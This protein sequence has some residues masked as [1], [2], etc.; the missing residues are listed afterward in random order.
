MLDSKSPDSSTALR[1]RFLLVA[2]VCNAFVITVATAVLIGWLLHIEHLKRIAPGM[3]AMN[4]LTAV[5]FI[6]AAA[7]LWILHRQPPTRIARVTAISVCGVVMLLSLFRLTAIFGWIDLG[8]DQWLFRSSLN[9]NHQAPNTAACTGI[10]ALSIALLDLQWSRRFYPTQLLAAGGGA[11]AAVALVG[12]AYSMQP[13]YGVST[14][15]PMA[16]HSAVC[17]IVLCF[18]VLCTRPDQGV[19]AVVTGDDL[20]G[21]LA[22]RLL[23]ITI[24]APILIGWLRLIAVRRG[25]VSD[26]LGNALLVMCVTAVFSLL[27]WINAQFLRRIDAHRRRAEAIMRQ[28][29]QR[30]RAV[31]QQTAEGIYLLDATSKRIVESN[32][33]FQRLLGY[34][35]A[36]AEQLTAYD[37]VNHQRDSIDQRVAQTLADGHA[38]MGE[39]QY[40]RR[41]GTCVDVQANASVITIDGQ[42][43]ICTVVHDITRRKT[44][45]REIQLKNKQLEEIAESERAALSELKRTQSQLVQTEKLAGLGQMVAGVAHEINN[46]LSFVSNNVAVL[47]RDLAAIRKLLEFYQQADALVEVG[48]KELM[49]EIRDLAERIDLPYTMKN[50]DELLVRSREG[51]RRIQQIVKDLREFARLDESDLHEVDLNEGIAS[52]VNIIKGNARKKQVEIEMDLQPLPAFSCYPAKINQVVMNLLSNAID[53]SPANSKVTVRARRGEGGVEIQVEDHGTGIPA[54]A[55]S[56]IFDPFY[57][58]KPPGEGTGLGLSISYGIVQDHGGR[59]DV[60]SEMGKGT[61]FTVRLP[62][63]GRPAHAQKDKK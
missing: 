4:P 48:N 39:R 49:Q 22:R 1:Q 53:A 6:L 38:I 3:V 58:T 13:L 24:A 37:I 50:S 23:A 46:P 51:L 10:M 17:F 18:G 47:Q 29:E 40:K 61:C 36:E 54:E 28:A 45:E 44:A 55:I 20:G 16:M 33:A 41:D 26:Q 19:M 15:F 2:A 9:G 62:W 43:V 30:Y 35:A 42:P 11:I 27:V 5:S 63:H 59:M 52:T 34:T 8:W 7:A 31:V 12:Y 21:I 56:R 14:F 57:T 32:T 60:E 25:Y